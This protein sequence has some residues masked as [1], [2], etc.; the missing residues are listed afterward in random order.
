MSSVAGKQLFKYHLQRNIRYRNERPLFFRRINRWRHDSKDYTFPISRIGYGLGYMKYGFFAYL[1][2]HYTKK[3]L[4]G[5][6]HS[7]D[8]HAEHH[9]DHHGSEHHAKI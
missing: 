7:H 1:G 2:W 6:H 3:I 4:F 9:H 8:H 5:D